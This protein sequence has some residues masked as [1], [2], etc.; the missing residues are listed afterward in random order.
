MLRNISVRGFVGLV[1]FDAEGALERE[2]GMRGREENESACCEVAKRR[3]KTETS[4]FASR[5]LQGKK[6]ETIITRA[7][8]EG[9]LRHYGA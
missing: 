3:H 1:G 8:E 7:T 9:K 5:Y 6:N 2:K 4:H